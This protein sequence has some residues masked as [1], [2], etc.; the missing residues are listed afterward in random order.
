MKDGQEVRRVSTCSDCRCLQV[1]TRVA[2]GACC[3]VDPARSRQPHQGGLRS[4]PLRLPLGAVGLQDPLL[5]LSHCPLPSCPA[6]ACRWDACGSDAY[7]WDACSSDTCSWDTL[8]LLASKVASAQAFA[9]DQP[10]QCT[11]LLQVKGRQNL[12]VPT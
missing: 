5:A 6:C 4:R 2:G 3:L 7:R 10:R 11:G 8:A 1:G 9:A 12:R